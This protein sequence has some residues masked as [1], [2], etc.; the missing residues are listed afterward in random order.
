PHRRR[1]PR[2][3]PLWPAGALPP[4]PTSAGTPG[5]C[6][7]R[8]A[9]GIGAGDAGAHER[10]GIAAAPVRRRRVSTSPSPSR[11]D[12]TVASDRR[13]LVLDGDLTGSQCVAGID[14]AFDDDS[15]LPVGVLTEPGSTCFVLTITR[16]LDDDAAVAMTRRI[17]R[18]VFVGVVP[19]RGLCVVS[20]SASSL[21]GHLIAL[22]FVLSEELA[23]HVIEV[24]AIT[25]C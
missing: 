8:R 10:T 19:A 24:D 18:G 6:D 17:L 22:P 12:P 7:P 21:R 25:L 2:G 16:A 9:G 5:A 23:V 13:L 20:R 3:R 1:A 15:A 4:P 14:V 11:K